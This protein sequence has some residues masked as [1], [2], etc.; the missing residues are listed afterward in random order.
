MATNEVYRHGTH[1]PL[2][3][4]TGTKSG[5]PVAASEAQTIPGVAVTDRVTG[6]T[7]ATVWCEGAWRLAVDGEVTET[8]TKLYIVADGTRQ[9]KLT[10]SDATGANLLFGYALEQKT[11]AVAPI[12]VLIARA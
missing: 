9:T 10:T 7:T 8:G 2:N 11:A 1:I 3:V 6:E 5:D 12:D 4:P